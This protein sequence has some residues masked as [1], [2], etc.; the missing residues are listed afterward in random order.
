MSKKKVY[1]YI[2]TTWEVWTYDVWGNEKDGFEVNNRFCENRN[3]EL[4]IRV[5]V[6]NKGTPREF[7][8]AYTSDTMLRR[9]FGLGGRSIVTEGDDVHIAVELARNGFP[10]GELFCTSHES[11]SPI[12][13]KA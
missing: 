2:N 6:C 3:L 5:E 8:H 12:K 13:E 10:V 1:S 4:R 7:E 9:I 11:L